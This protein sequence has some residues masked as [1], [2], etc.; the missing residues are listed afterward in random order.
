[1]EG[2]I[3]WW[4]RGRGRCR[5]KACETVIEDNGVGQQ[6]KERRYHFVLI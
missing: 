6:E 5:V 4:F 1:M 2:A 3:G